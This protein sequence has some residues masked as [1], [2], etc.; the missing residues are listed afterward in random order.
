[1]RYFASPNTLLC[2]HLNHAK[3]SSFGLRGGRSSLILSKNKFSEGIIDTIL[4]GV[5]VGNNEDEKFA[6]QLRVPKLPADPIYEFMCMY[7]RKLKLT[8]IIDVIF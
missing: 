1:M 6:Q 4:H 8:L 5:K 2:C 7:N 3:R